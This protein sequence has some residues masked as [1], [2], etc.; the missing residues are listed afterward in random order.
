LAA[1]IAEAQTGTVSG[2]VVD[3]QGAAV[4][5]AHILVQPDHGAEVSAD[6]NAAGRFS[7][8]SPPGDL[9]LSVTAAGFAVST[10]D[11]TLAP[12]SKVELPTIKLK[13]A[14]LD[15]SVDAISV[16]DLAEQQI[17]LQETQRLL[18]VLP[19]FFV[20]YVPNAAPLTT[21]QKFELSYHTF[22]DPSVFIGVGIGAAITQASNTPKEWGQDWAGYGQR[23]GAAY[24]GA[25]T[26]ATLVGTVFPAVFHQDPRFYMSYGTKK[27]QFWGALKQVVEQKGDNGKW[28]PAYSRLLSSTASTL[29]VVAIYPHTDTN[30]GATAAENFG[31]SIGASALRNVLQQFVFSKVTKRK[32]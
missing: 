21:S 9:L 4:P 23:Y 31:I 7:I 16:H 6:T 2:S 25:V 5:A 3:S 8:V 29:V 14:G 19:N 27:E 13:L 28:Q 18:G 32:K 20:S 10:V 30:F 12:G 24:A 17:K 15:T 1:G 22:L 26:R 11:T